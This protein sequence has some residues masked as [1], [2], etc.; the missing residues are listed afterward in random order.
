M[1]KYLN[2]F[3]IFKYN[4][5]LNII[6]ANNKFKLL[7]NSLR[8]NISNSLDDNYYLNRFSHYLIIRI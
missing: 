5:Y 6:V 3:R 8:F 2:Y 7:K 4:E 1:S